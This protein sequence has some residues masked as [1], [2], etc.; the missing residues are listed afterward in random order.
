[1]TT[2]QDP[3]TICPHCGQP[4]AKTQYPFYRII[5]PALAVGAVIF[6]RFSGR[7]R[8]DTAYSGPLAVETIYYISS[9]RADSSC[10]ACLASAENF[11]DEKKKTALGKKI[12]DMALIPAG[13]YPVGSPDE[14]GDPDEH[15]RRQISLAAFYIDKFETTI[16]DYMKFSAETGGHYPDWAKPGGRFNLET[17]KE[18]YYARLADLFKTC[19]TCPIVGISFENAADYCGARGK[20]LPTEAEWEAA[21]R[22]GAP[23]AFSFSDDPAAAGEYS[24]NET[25]SG[26]EPHPVGGRKPNAYGLHDMHGNVWEWTADIYD[27]KYYRYGQRRNPAGPEKGDEHVIRGGSWAF[28]AAALRSANRAQTSKPNDDIGFRC[29][30]SGNAAAGGK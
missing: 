21:A 20:R 2:R 24:W 28:D 5:I 12:K 8:S 6:F 15:R 9:P 22:G 25:N 27:K 7:G 14:L 23:S 29:A 16:T 30:A 17:G 11:L 13:E 3:K 18:P 26:S 1:M 4:A 10:Q 19:G